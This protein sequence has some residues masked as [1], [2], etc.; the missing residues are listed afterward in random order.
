MPTS[1]M[2]NNK[3]CFVPPP[4]ERFRDMQ[5][6]ESSKLELPLRWNMIQK[7]TPTFANNMT[8]YT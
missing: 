5:L 8:Y 4:V 2:K 1:D 3:Q 6:P 7:M